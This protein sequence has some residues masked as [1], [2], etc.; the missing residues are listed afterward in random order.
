MRCLITIPLALLTLGTLRA[1]TGI[2]CDPDSDCYYVPELLPGETAPALLILS[3]VGATPRDVDSNLVVSDSL[4]W[5]LASCH[6]SRNH[7]SGEE[8]DRDIMNTLGKLLSNCP[9]DRRRIYICGFSGMGAQSLLELILH[10]ALFR[11]A[12]TSCSPGI[13]LPLSSG[14]DYTSNAAYIVTREND[15][16]LDGNR[17]L[18]E[19]LEQ[20]GVS[21]RL[22]VTAGKHEPGGTD[23]LLAGC[24]W[25]LDNTP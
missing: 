4:G 6:G 24:R 18:R 15:W 19:R 8:N 17:S 10:P 20:T 9:V 14:Q 22:A 21:C 7:R 1:E 16:N 5:I 25:L 13:E 12:V 11:G 3:C 2:V 23:E